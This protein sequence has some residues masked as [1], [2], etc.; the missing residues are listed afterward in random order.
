MGMIARPRLG[1]DDVSFAPVKLFSA[2]EPEIESIGHFAHEF[3]SLFAALLFLFLTL[4]TI[5]LGFVLP[6]F[7]LVLNFFLFFP[8]IVLRKRLVL[9]R[10][11]PLH[12]VAIEIHHLVG[13]YLVGLHMAFS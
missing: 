7:H 4:G 3:P 6:R 9:F 10:D 11:K 13:L 5:L 1:A 12:P 8:R 2:L